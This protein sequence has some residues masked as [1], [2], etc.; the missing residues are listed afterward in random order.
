MRRLLFGSMAVLSIAT[1]I[2]AAPPPAIAPPAPVDSPV[3][4]RAVLIAP[5]PIPDRVARA[6]TIVTGKV[7]SIEEKT[8]SVPAAPGSKEKVE[9]VIAVVK[10]DDA[11]Q[12][13]KD[14]THIKV[15]FQAPQAAGPG[16]PIRPGIGRGM[17]KLDKDQEVLLFLSPHQTGEFNVMQMYFDVVDKSAPT[18]EKDLEATKKCVKLLAEPEKGLKSKDAQE[19]LD[20]AALLIFKYR[21]FKPS[22]AQ[23]KEEPIDADMSK[24][25][26]NALADGDWTPPKVGGPIGNFQMTPQALFFRLGVTDKD[27]WKPPQDGN[28]FQEAVETWVKENKDKYRIKK[29]VYE[30]ADKKD[31]KKEPKKEK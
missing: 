21:A 24:L 27:G 17:A 16:R 4:D 13:G 31:D 5:A 8:V 11:I 30:K 23:P 1:L 15:G 2:Y 26:M 18:Y 14:L 25:I 10:V 7:T 6:D 12:G 19:R 29:L 9:Y 28:N 22:D 3:A 20:T